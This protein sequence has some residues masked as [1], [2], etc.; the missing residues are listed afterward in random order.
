MSTH[1]LI[2]AFVTGLAIFSI[3]GT[4]A[5][6]NMYLRAVIIGVAGAFILSALLP[7]Y[8]S[9]TSKTGAIP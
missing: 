5:S 8:S 1:N 4:V 9:L 6:R 2:A 7:I 3:A